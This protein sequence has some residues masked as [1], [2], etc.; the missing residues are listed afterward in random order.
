MAAQRRLISRLKEDFGNSPVVANTVFSFL[1]AG[2]EK[3]VEVEFACPCD[4]KWNASFAAAFFVIPAF[5]SFLLMLIIHECKCPNHS[6]KCLY[7]I[8]PPLVWHVLVFLDGQYFV[9]A[10]TDWPGTFVSVDKTY[11]KWCTPTNT[12]RTEELMARSRKQFILSQVR[13]V[14]FVFVFR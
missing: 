9:C 3:I 1:L 6:P 2:V 11:L 12:T 10:T 7:S 4:P 14:S 8:L 13:K 5:F